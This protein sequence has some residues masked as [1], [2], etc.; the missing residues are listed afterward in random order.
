MESHKTVKPHF[1]QAC[2]HLISRINEVLDSVNQTT[3]VKL[4][5][6]KKASGTTLQAIKEATNS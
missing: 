6:A 1:S 2:D 3:D 5:S 4:K